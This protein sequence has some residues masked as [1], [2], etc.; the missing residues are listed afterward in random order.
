MF[1]SLQVVTSTTSYLTLLEQTTTIL[2][3]TLLSTQAL[4]PLSG[5]TNLLLPT[6]PP[7]R[8]TVTL[9][10]TISMPMCQRLKRQFTKLNQHARN[11]MGVESIAQLFAQYLED[12]T[13]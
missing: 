9:N 11:E 13:R 5:P 3:T 6:T 10:K 2:I 12:A 1:E 7:V 4:S 8:I